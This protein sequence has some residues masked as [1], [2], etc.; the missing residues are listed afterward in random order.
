MT[1]CF[2]VGPRDK[3][4]HFKVYGIPVYKCS[5]ICNYM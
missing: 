2:A 5:I 3:A 4:F 1:R